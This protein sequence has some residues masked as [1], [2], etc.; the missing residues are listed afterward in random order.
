MDTIRALVADP[1]APGRLSLREVAA[2]KPAPSEAV[3]TVE[4]VSLNRGEVRALQTAE[5]GWRPGWDLA[6]VVAEAAADGSGPRT[7]AP[8][9]G[10]TRQGAW[11]EQVAVATNL[12]AH[13]PASVSAAVA[14]TLPVAGLTA[15]RAVDLADTVENRAVLVTGASGGV[16]RFAIQLAAQLGADVTAL[17]SSEERGR[18]LVA[19]GAAAFAVELPADASFDLI[20]DSVGGYVL[21]QALQ[22]VGPGGLIV[23]FG[24]SSGQ[25]TTFDV[26]RFY[27][28]DGAR[29]YAFLIFSELSRSGSGAHDLGR[30]AV[31]AG[32]G[33]LDVGI[34]REAAWTE[35]ADVVEA[36]WQRKIAGKTV[37]HLS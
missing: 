2:P 21:G 19:L 8:V 37:L 30:L 9:V 26:S 18:P 1:S 20:L 22:S 5:E 29:L 25:P 17:V 3:V 32:E 14:A 15:L 28:R 11:A 34:G 13:R 23:S 10:L 6:G 7:G 33:H 35:A 36:F 4:A 24:N 27:P 16:G 12:L 31:M